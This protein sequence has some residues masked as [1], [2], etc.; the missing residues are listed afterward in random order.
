MY[1]LQPHNISQNSILAIS[2]HVALCEGHLRIEPDLTLF[3]YYFSVKK[4]SVP[5]ANT[6]ANCG[7]A[8]FKIRRDCIYPQTDRHESVRYWSARFFYVKDAEMP[9]NTRRLPPFKDGPT[10]EVSAWNANPHISDFPE[11]EKKAK[12]ISKLVSSGLT[13]KDL[14]LFWFTKR[15]QPLQHREILMYFYSSREDNMRATKDNLSLD[16]LDKR[17]Q[18]MIK[19]PRE[20]HSHACGTD[21]YTEGAGPSFDSLE[22]KD[23]GFLVR[24]PISGPSNPDPASDAEKDDETEPILPSKRKRESEYGNTSKRGRGVRGSKVSSAATKI[25]EKEKLRLKEIDTS[26][27]GGID[28]FFYQDQKSGEKPKKKAKPSLATMPITPEVEAPSKPAPSTVPTKEKDVIQI[29]DDAED[30]GGSGKGTSSK[31]TSIE[32]EQQKTLAK[33]PADDAFQRNE[34]AR[35][36]P[37]MHPHLFPILLRALLHQCCN[38]ITNLMNEVWG[39][40]ETEKEDLEEFED[41]FLTFFAKHKTIRQSTRA[42]H[43]EMKGVTLDQKHQIEELSAKEVESNKAVEVLAQ[44]LLTSRPSVDEISAKLKML[45]AEHESVQASLKE[46]QANEIKLK[47]ELEAKHALATAELEKKLKESDERVKSLSSQLEATDAEA[48]TIDNIIFRKFSLPW[49]PHT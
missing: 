34:V 28:Q 45:E 21:I 16:A 17:L 11:I 38:E 25:L 46:S 23:L 40:P 31:M 37:S 42:L 29:D 10:T 9:E 32:E 41:A 2:N 43:T 33:A 27:K 12:W 30:V 47:K 8:T 7:S 14:T 5:K 4:E 36:T 44:H 13:G 18:V 3:Q 39:N 49:F 35:G 24:T 26:K 15:I 6:L 1:Q 48:K 19:I 22:E 20:V